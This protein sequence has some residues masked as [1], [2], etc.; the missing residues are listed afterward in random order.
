MGNGDDKLRKKVL[1]IA[2]N[3][4]GALNIALGIIVIYWGIRYDMTWIA[5]KWPCVIVGSL[6][7]LYGVAAIE[8]FKE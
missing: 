2:V 4:A 7:V 6:T 3:L 5:M 8:V 1:A